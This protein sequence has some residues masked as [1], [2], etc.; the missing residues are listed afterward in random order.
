MLNSNHP[1]AGQTVEEGNTSSILNFEGQ[2]CKKSLLTQMCVQ[3]QAFSMYDHLCAMF[4]N[5][6]KG[7]PQLQKLIFFWGCSKWPLTTHIIGCQFHFQCST[8]IFV[9]PLFDIDIHIFEKCWNDDIS[10]TPSPGK[11]WYK[12]IQKMIAIASARGCTSPLRRL[13]TSGSQRWS[14]LDSTASLTVSN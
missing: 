8:N 13:P 14:P 2:V 6:A 11:R 1:E 4:V 5:E 12:N 7:S 10:N 9:N 3:P